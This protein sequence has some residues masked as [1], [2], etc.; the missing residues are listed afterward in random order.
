MLENVLIAA[1]AISG[2]AALLHWKFSEREVSLLDAVLCVL[3]GACFGPIL[4]TLRFLHSIK[5]KGG[6]DVDT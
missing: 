3:I 4:P 6:Q 2:I 5:L 1:W